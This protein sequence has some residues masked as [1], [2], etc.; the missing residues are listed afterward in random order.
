MNQ[1]LLH[2]SKPQNNY[3]IISKSNPSQDKVPPSLTRNNI[4]IFQ[5][6][7]HPYRFPIAERQPA[8]LSN[9]P[10]HT[11]TDGVVEHH[12]QRACLHRS[13]SSSFIKRHVRKKGK[14]PSSIL[15]EIVH[16]Y[17]ISNE[18]T[19]P[20]ANGPRKITPPPTQSSGLG[21][22]HVLTSPF[23]VL[24]FFLKKRG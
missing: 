16:V 11:R 12:V 4:L 18:R 10:N 5:P 1:Q 20:Q 3:P 2:T 21:D 8:D 19:K 14:K 13:S 9:S 15:F 23:F 6:M 22:L 17:N 7:T 24:C